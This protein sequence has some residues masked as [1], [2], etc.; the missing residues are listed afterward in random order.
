[1]SSF[2]QM[3]VTTSDS[4]IQL[5]KETFDRELTVFLQAV[6]ATSVTADKIVRAPVPSANDRDSEEEEHTKENKGAWE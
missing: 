1:M 6:A 3:P 5:L 4:F 2:Y